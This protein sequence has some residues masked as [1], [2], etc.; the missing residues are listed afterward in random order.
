[1]L[2]TQHQ[3]T[4]PKVARLC[5][6]GGF[7]ISLCDILQRMYKLLDKVMCNHSFYISCKKVKRAYKTLLQ[8]KLVRKKWSLMFFWI[9]E[10]SYKTNNVKGWE[11]VMRVG[12]KAFTMVMN[13]N[14]SDQKWCTRSQI[15]YKTIYTEH[16]NLREKLKHEIT[17]LLINPLLARDYREKKKTSQPL[18]T[19]ALLQ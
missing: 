9:V 2:V 7:L 16:Q 11:Y 3:S 14:R 4:C 5:L 6:I 18:F 10:Y 19:I 12:T 17:E 13:K 8:E 1:M 15:Y